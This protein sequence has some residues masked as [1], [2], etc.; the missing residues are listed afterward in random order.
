[1]KRFPAAP[2]LLLAWSTALCFVPLVNLLAFEFAVF[3]TLPVT[4]ISASRGMR[5]APV[6]GFGPHA[7]ALLGSIGLTLVPLVPISLNALRIPNCNFTE[8]L[9]FYLVLPGLTAPVAHLWGLACARVSPK[10]PR[11]AFFAVFL[12]SLAAPLGFF[13]LAP[14]VDAFHAFIGYYPGSLYDEVIPLTGRLVGARLIDLGFASAAALAASGGRRARL[15]ALGLVGSGMAAGEFGLDLYRTSAHVQAEL[16]GLAEAPGLRMHYPREL[17]AERVEGLMTELAFRYEELT[18][19]FGRAPTAPI[20]VWFYADG[21]QKKRLMGADAVRI[22]KPWQ[23]AVHLQLPDIG[24]GVL[25]HELAHAFSAEISAAPHHLSLN[26]WGLPN[27]GLIEGVAVAAAWEDSPLD[28][29]QW[30]LA[31]RQLGVGKDL[32]TLL[33]PHGFLATNSRAAYTQCGSYVRWLRDTAGP[34]A[35]EALYRRGMLDTSSD[36]RPDPVAEWLRFLE[37][38]T[39]GESALAIARLRFDRPA[40]FGKTCAHEIAALRAKLDG[41]SSTDVD[42]AIEVVDAILGHLP[43]DPDA[44]LTRIALLARRAADDPKEAAATLDAADALAARPD[45]GLVRR[46]RA[47]E[48]QADLRARR[49]TPADVAFARAVYDALADAHFDRAF[50]RRVAVKRAGLDGG[51]WGRAVLALLLAP[52]D[53]ARST[54]DARLDEIV[55]AAPDHPITRYLRGRQAARRGETEAAVQHSLAALEAGLP[56]PAL[57]FEALR[58]VAATRFQGGDYRAAAA[59]YGG[60]AARTDLEIEAG[61]RAALETWARRARFFAGRSP[62]TAGTGAD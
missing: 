46:A 59:A 2:L 35:V 33:S 8:G 51:P 12:F 37:T 58:M 55:T 15:V 39:V 60:L 5:A 42:A 38:R 13:A 34:E 62:G 4:L 11:W 28:A 40:I 54:A 61:E 10:R 29:H 45:I 26:D 53:A 9:L 21:R 3:T 27:M 36:E 20:E 41:I 47:R 49:G 25:A 31:M 1:V 16:G 56:H 7:R 18:R 22:A 32:R 30:T 24:D 6:S 48:W 23:R 44:I 14:P 50:T 52:E 19:F 43:N 57:T 17:P